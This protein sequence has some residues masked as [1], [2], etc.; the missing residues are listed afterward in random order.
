VLCDQCHVVPSSAAAVGHSDSPLPAE[1]SF[2]ALAGAPSWNGASCANAYCHGAT[3][4][5]GAA[6]TPVWSVVDGSQS[7]CD[8]CH[9]APPP[10]PHATSTSCED[11]HGAVV[12]P[13]MVITTPVNHI[14]GVLQADNVHPALWA[15]A[16]AHGTAY[17]EGTGGDCATSS[18]HGVTLDGGA[19]GISCNDCHSGWKTDCTFCHGGGDNL[20]GAPPAAV[21]GSISRALIAV[22]AHT[23]HVEATP[24][25]APWD[26]GLCHV[27]PSSAVSPSHIDGDGIA[28]VVFSGLNS[29][30]SF[31]SGTGQ[32]SSLYCHGNGRTD[33]GA[34][35]WT[36]DPV[37]DCGQCHESGG[38]ADTMSGKHKKH[39]VDK[40][41]EC[42]EC[43]YAVVSPALTIIGPSLHVDGVM[44]VDFPTSGTWNAGSGNCSS[45][46]GGA[47][48]GSKNW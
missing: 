7:Q 23:D 12:G 46:P 36:A 19:S 30:A 10:P 20:T 4:T 27:E 31:N 22:G 16:D 47:C 14:D 5:G 26:C 21:D 11:C 39:I 13:G 48:H 40:G 45:L 17:N 28:E 38:P 3:L 34:E 35:L 41:V 42:Y 8:S 18:C 25:H 29:A 37:Y 9:G 44:D 2:G 43:H 6:T 24:T 33:N 32:C 1:L 15:D